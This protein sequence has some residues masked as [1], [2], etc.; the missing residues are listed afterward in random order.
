MFLEEWELC[1]G[2][3][4]EEDG[5]EEDGG[6]EDGGGGDGGEEDEGGDDG[7]E[8][9]EGGEREMADQRVITGKTDGL[10]PGSFI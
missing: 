9:D 4:L 6:E 1:S 3:E 8:E 10:M 7:G 5:G 2:R